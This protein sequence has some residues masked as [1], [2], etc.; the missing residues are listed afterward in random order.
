[1]RGPLAL[2]LVGLALVGGMAGP[3][4]AQEHQGHG[5]AGEVSFPSSCAPEVQADLNR[6]VALLH[7]FWWTRTREAF[8]A[9][10]Q[11]DPGCGVA[12]WGLALGWAENMLSAPPTPERSQAAWA[13]VEQGR[14]AGARTPRERGYLGA[15][16]A[17][18]KE[19]QTVPWPDRA[20]AYE[21]AMEQLHLSHPEDREAAIFYALA[22]N[23]T[24]P[25]ADKGYTQQRKAAAILERAFAEQPQHPGVAHYLIHSYD[26]P[27]LA[28]QGL[29]FARVYTGLAPAVPHARH[30]P[31][32]TFTRLGLWE[33]SIR[34]NLAAVEVAAGSDWVHAQDYLAY[35]YLQRGQQDA[36]KRVVDEVAQRA[37]AAPAVL[38]LVYGHT[39]PPARY[40]YERGRWD[41]AAALAPGQPADVPWDRFPQAEAVTHQA[42]AIGA[43]RAGDPAAARDSLARLE[44]LRDTLAER[45]DAYW[46][47][48]VDIWRAEAAAWI[49][50]A[51]GQNADALQAMRW[52]ADTEAKTDKHIVWPGP[53]APAREM[54]GELLLAAGE[55]AQALAEFEASLANE[56]DRLRGLYGAGRAAE[57]ANDRARAAGLY[58]R[59]LEVAAPAEGDW[60]ELAAARA[61]LDADVVPAR[62]SPAEFPAASAQVTRALQRTGG[63]PA[64]WYCPIS[65]DG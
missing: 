40:A 30:M 17:L 18:F 3:V 16:E 15:V 22:L 62:A 29:R 25:P 51:E 50:H 52:A 42:R 60:P 65:V 57:L 12:F 20:L 35:A 37:F 23:I 56:P 27:S 63:A 31:S 2:L 26:Y 10:A 48:Q 21:R 53:L 32:H 11:R 34:S 61:A 59:L 36:A 28:E 64:G 46:A 55:P 41:E 44:A 1:M 39:L 14:A 7:S 5:A 43:A 8:T 54:L 4:R 45:R 58:R 49:A 6:A 47:E 38:A 24:A 19:H 9:V 33:E 13:A